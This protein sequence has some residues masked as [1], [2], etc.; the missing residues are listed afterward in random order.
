MP[1]RRL[2]CLFMHRVRMAESAVLFKLKFAGR[3]LLILRRIVV[4]VLALRTGQ[5]HYV[6][7]PSATLYRL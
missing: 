4:P 2:L 6:S 5:Y 3:L 7:H 1:H